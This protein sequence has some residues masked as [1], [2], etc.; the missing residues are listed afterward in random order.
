MLLIDDDEDIREVLR[1]LV[2]EWGHEVD[3]AADGLEGVRK[4]LSAHP[5]F[6]LVDL[7][8]PLLG[9]LE[10]A[11]RVRATERGRSIHLVAMSGHGQAKDRVASYQAGFEAHL[12]KPIDPL[13]LATLLDGPGPRR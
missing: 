4:L 5:D 2:E 9:G 7:G 13:E 11:R 12:V 1:A 8:L 6:A 3:V 10:I